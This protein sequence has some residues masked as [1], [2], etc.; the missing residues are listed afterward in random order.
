MIEGDFSDFS[1]AVMSKFVNSQSLVLNS[2]WHIYS[3][4]MQSVGSIFSLQGAVCH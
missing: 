2:L 3:A 4:I 1:V